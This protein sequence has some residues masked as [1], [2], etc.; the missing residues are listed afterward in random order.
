MFHICALNTTFNFLC[1]NGTIFSQEALVCVWW[2]QFD[3]NTAPNLFGN[4]AY[5][6]DYSKTGQQQDNTNAGFSGQGGSFDGG[7]GATQPGSVPGFG[8]PIPSQ[9]FGGSQPS[10]PGFGSSPAGSTGFGSTHSTAPGF[11]GAA[12]SPAVESAPGFGSTHSAS[13]GFGSSATGYPAAGAPSPSHS[14]G[15]S[16]SPGKIR[17]FNS[18]ISNS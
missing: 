9:G 7:F 15:S 17:T 4:N 11:V 16:H 10:A 3:C 14:S 8:A 6:Y 5:I 2:N 12:H 18:F 1:P 13:P